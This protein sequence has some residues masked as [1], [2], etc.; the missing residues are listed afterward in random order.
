MNPPTIEAA[1]QAPLPG[2]ETPADVEQKRDRF[3]SFREVQDMPPA[4]REALFTLLRQAQAGDPSAL[5][6]VMSVAYQERPV[7]IDE[8][9]LGRR[10]LNL[11]GL[12]NP[13]KLDLLAR[14][15]HPRVRHVY[16]A[17]GSGAGK[18]FLVSIMLARV[19]YR[20]LC[21]RRPDLYYLLGPGSGIAAVCLSVSK[22]QARDVVYA[23]FKGRLE[24]APW[25][26]GKYKPYKYHATFDKKLAVF[27]QSKNPT[28]SYGYNT[29]FAALDECCFMV[30]NEEKS[31]AE[32]L[33]EAVMKSMNSRFP[34]SYKFMAIS[35]LRDRDDYL[36]KEIDR[37]KERGSRVI[38]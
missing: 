9:V 25:F 20:L 28:V 17:C 19:M 4:D 5:D 1:V 12:I 2:I 33:A 3:Y 29:F 35:T 30:D 26:T 21:L 24:H 11:R 23:E 38:V 16:L 22:E 27:C 13:E 37:I 18:S 6:T 32:D 31:L 10:Y 15:D 14:I 7:P 8:F 36:S 34:G